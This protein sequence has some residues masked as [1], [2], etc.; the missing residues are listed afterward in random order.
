[1]EI[2]GSVEL[3]SPAV[4]DR[5]TRFRLQIPLTVATEAGD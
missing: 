3:V 4:G 2:G 5:G 1:V